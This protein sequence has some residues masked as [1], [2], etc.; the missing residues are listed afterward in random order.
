MLNTVL[1]GIIKFLLHMVFWVFVLS[2]RWD[3]RTI[4]DR[5]HDILVDNP[6]IE[7]VDEHVTAIWVAFSGKL[8]VALKE[9]ESSKERSNF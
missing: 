6:L 5:A 9:A 2:I 8:D 4:F 1:T 7:E 3:E